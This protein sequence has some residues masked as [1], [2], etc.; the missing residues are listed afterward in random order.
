MTKA[1]SWATGKYNEACDLA[2]GLNQEI[3]RALALLKPACPDESLE[4]AIRN[5]QQVLVMERAHVAKLEADLTSL[6][7]Y[8]AS[9]EDHRA[10]LV[11]QVNELSRC[12]SYEL[13]SV[14]GQRYSVNPNAGMGCKLA[15]HIEAY[16]A[17]V[18]KVG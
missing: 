5:L 3:A 12:L 18:G 14:C 4:G 17:I 10:S 13:C 8:V 1:C 6:R 2:E 9:A 15:D 11:A 7:G 16:E